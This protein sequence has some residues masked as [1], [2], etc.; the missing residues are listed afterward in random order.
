MNTKNLKAYAPKARNQFIEAVKKRAAFFGIYENEIMPIT[1]QGDTAII[2]GEAFTKA[3]GK[4][5]Q[6]LEK[7]IEQKG[8]ELFIREMAYTWFNRLAALRFMEL[9]DYLEHGFRV[10]SNPARSDELPEI[11]DHAADVADMLKLD[12][13]HITELQLAGDKQEILYRELLLGQCHYL[14][15]IMPFLFE[16]LDDATELLLPDN[17]TKTDSILKGLVNDIP[18]EDWKQIEVI[19]WLYQFYISEHKDAVIGKVVKSEDIPA[20]TQLFTPNWIVKYLVQNSVGRQWL[21]TYPNSEIKDKMD[22]YIEPAAQTDEVN[23]RLAE[24]TP[25][26]IDPESIKTLD[27]ATGSGHILVEIYELLRE[28]YLERGYRL[29]EIPELILTK[30]IYGLDIDDRAAQLASFALMMKAH[31]DDKRIFQRVRDGNV[32]INVYSLQTTENWDSVALWQA[33]NLEGKAKQGN[34]GDLFAESTQLIPAPAGVY[35]EYFD[36]LKYLI[37]SFEQAKTLGS[38]IQIDHKYLPSLEQFKEKLLNQTKNKDPATIAVA[39]Q[40]LPVVEQAI[41]L[42]SK[43]DAVIANPPYMGS[44]GQNA[45]IKRYLSESFPES[46]AD[47]YAAFIK[48]SYDLISPKGHSAMITMQGWMF[49]PSFLKLRKDLIEATRVINLIHLGGRAFPEISGEVVQSCA[50][51]FGRENIPSFCPTFIDLKAGNSTQKQGNL[52]L[53]E[54]RYSE[55]HQSEFLT[56]PRSQ[57]LYW[58]PSAVTDAFKKLSFVKSVTTS[59]GQTKTGDNDKYIRCFWEVCIDNLG[60]DKK[61]VKHPRGGGN[62]KWYGNLDSVIDWSAQAKLHYRKDRV[63]RIIPEYLWWEEGVTWSN[64]AT[65]GFLGFRKLLSDEIFNMNAPSLFFKEVDS[66]YLVGFLNSSFSSY[67]ANCYNPTLHFNVADVQFIPFAKIKESERLAILAEKAIDISKQDW[68]M[69]ETSVDF[70]K[71]PLIG[72]ER[73]L[74]SSLTSYLQGARDDIELLKKIEEEINVKVAE[75]YSLENALEINVGEEKVT[76]LRN[77]IWSIDRK[78]NF[79]ESSKLL[80]SR[81]LVELLGFFMGC[82]AGRYSL[83]RDGLV[84]AHSNKDGFKDLVEEGAYKSFPADDDGIIPLASEEWLFEDDATA[85]F[86]EFLK[87]VWGAEHLHDNLE[88]VA[89]S[90]CLNAIKIKKDE[91][92][93]QT[94]R[95]YLSSQFYSDHCKIYKK[96]PIYWLFSSGK[97]KAFEC[98]VYIHRYNEGTLSRIRTEYVT[99]L[100]GKY[101]SQYNLLTEQVAQSN[102]TEQRRI[103]KEL[104]ALAKKQ[105]ELRKFDEEHKHYAEMRITLDLDDGVKANYGKFGN[106]LANVEGIHGK[107]VK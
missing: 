65:S 1:F 45:S 12:K 69:F 9:H 99:P 58:I 72:L 28:I 73:T 95:R 78:H 35:A 70:K 25:N 64:I 98:L 37:I 29:R 34:N 57:L 30:N 48:R 83:D 26:S 88:F 56:Y 23:T 66:N 40:L 77:P 2:G 5:R 50:F 60:V 106:M 92:A 53:Q 75:H 87:I 20:V 61:W 31:E 38:L 3:Q 24:I 43:Y 17:L 33:L 21:A 89:E 107:A 59:D 19:G 62:K 105:V 6:Q 71:N 80:Q 74:R 79:D 100:M 93:I 86:R 82:I 42:A 14:H 47:I 8:F 67:M 7:R 44:N 51:I 102:G 85:R 94:I 63:A 91:S 84:F 13:A 104:K 4:K 22:F 55:K 49:L 39:G 36:L 90:L 103:E 18:E 32:K 68:D 54:L 11:L 15:N 27:P 10:L 101:E 46:K 41:L 96:R 76:L 16:A 52:K 81:T 97:E